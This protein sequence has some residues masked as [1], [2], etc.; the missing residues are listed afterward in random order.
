MN[1]TLLK[2]AIVVSAL[3]LASAASAQMMRGGG[4]G[5]VGSSCKQDIARYCAQV[6]HGAG[7]VPQCLL[8]HKSDLS[9][10]CRQALAMKGPGG[11]CGRNMRGCARMR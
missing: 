7:M 9:G 4:Q 11:G 3:A 2:T 8:Q 10:Q 1:K 6:S 5:L